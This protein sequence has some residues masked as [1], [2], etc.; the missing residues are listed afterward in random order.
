MNNQY[1][2]P[3]AP[4]KF[5]EKNKE[6]IETLKR[7][8]SEWFANQKIIKWKVITPHQKIFAQVMTA[9]MVII[10]GIVSIVFLFDEYQKK[11]L[12]MQTVFIILALF[13]LTTWY[14]YRFFQYETMPIIIYRHQRKGFCG[15]GQ[16][17][18]TLKYGKQS[19][20][21]AFRLPETTF[22]NGQDDI[23]T[24]VQMRTALQQAIHQETGWS[25]FYDH[26][27]YRTFEKE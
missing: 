15:S 20:L 8:H 21:P 2:N 4:K 19:A 10:F 17:K 11:G 5:Q 18:Q 24:Y 3:Y 6:A 26:K 7:V 25:F 13:V 9:L 1:T 23:N 12:S 27:A 14:L 22:N 16:W